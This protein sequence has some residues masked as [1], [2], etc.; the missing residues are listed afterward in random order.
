LQKQGF[1]ALRGY[2]SRV[3]IWLRLRMGFSAY[4][5]KEDEISCCEILRYGCLLVVV[6]Q[7]RE[8]PRREACRKC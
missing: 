5:D 2:L 4:C 3:P 7:Q 1:Y 8:Q 6:G